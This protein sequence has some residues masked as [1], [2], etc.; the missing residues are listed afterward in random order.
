MLS[1]ELLVASSN[2]EDGELSVREGEREQKIQ[3]EKDRE[4]GWRL[5]QR[6]PFETSFILRMNNLSSSSSS[7]FLT[8]AARHEPVVR[9]HTDMHKHTQINTHSLTHKHTPRTTSVCIH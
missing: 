6:E 3:R 4:K 7:S 9:K 2:L 8:Q 1:L 5:Q